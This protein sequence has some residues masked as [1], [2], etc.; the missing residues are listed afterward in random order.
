MLRKVRILLAAIAFT[1]ITL[2]FLD[3][4]GA[5]HQ[6]LGWLATIQFLPA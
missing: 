5:L 6:W 3:I 1:A 2:L 4:S